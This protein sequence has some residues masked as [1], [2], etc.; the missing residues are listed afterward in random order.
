MYKFEF[1]GSG[2]NNIY[3]DNINIYKGAPSESLVIGLSENS[4][5]SELLL[6]PNP[7]GEEM[8]IQFSLY[9][10]S[11][12][13]IIITDLSGKIVSSTF[14]SALTGSNIVTVNTKDISSGVYFLNLQVNGVKRVE[15][16]VVK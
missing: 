14:V 4:E 8:N 6:F 12:T 9:S 13:D 15:R 1:E 10:S 16:F 11:R 3:L 2:G 7:A 5:I